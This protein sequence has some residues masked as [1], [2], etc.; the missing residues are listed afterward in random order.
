MEKM[1]PLL[2]LLWLRWG[3]GVM[4]TPPSPFIP[5]SGEHIP[6]Y[7]LRSPCQGNLSLPIYWDPLCHWLGELGEDLSIL[8]SSIV[9][10]WMR[11][12][13]ARQY[14]HQNQRPCFHMQKQAFQSSTPS[15]PIV[16]DRE[17]GEIMRLVAS[18]C[19]SV[20]L[21]VF[22]SSPVWTVWP[23]TLIFSMGVDFGLG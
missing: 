22:P 17:A 9:G 16:I 18:V 5:L 15:L 20:C 13:F 6:P 19:L 21:S 3:Q 11:T 14:L 10:Y 23:R 2:L 4:G 7:L 1:F 8:T 12:A